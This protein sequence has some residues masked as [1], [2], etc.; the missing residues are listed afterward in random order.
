MRVRQ[1]ELPQDP[2]ARAIVEML[3]EVTVW[4]HHQS[5]IFEDWLAVRVK[6]C[7]D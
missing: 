1:R 4:G 2:D 6:D 3:A 7:D 5:D